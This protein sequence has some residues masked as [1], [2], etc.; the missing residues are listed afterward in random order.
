[1]AEEVVDVEGKVEQAKQTIEASTAERET[2]EAELPPPLVK[3]VKRLEESRQGVF[4]SKT[5]DGTCLK[6]STCGATSGCS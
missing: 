3:S 1:M 5:D 4:L 6:C 2:I